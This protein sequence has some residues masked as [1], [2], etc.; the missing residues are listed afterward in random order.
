MRY[1][2][3]VDGRGYFRFVPAHQAKAEAKRGFNRFM[4]VRVGEAL[5]AGRVSYDVFHWAVR[6]Y[7][8]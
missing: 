7:D 4:S 6:H 5:D 2:F 3:M 1:I 8:F